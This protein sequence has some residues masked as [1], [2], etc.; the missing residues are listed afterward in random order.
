MKRV[1]YPANRERDG[2]RRVL[3]RRDTSAS[4]SDVLERDDGLRSDEG[5]ASAGSSDVNCLNFL[6]NNGHK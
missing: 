4:V 3:V 1:R 2:S 5:S 6:I